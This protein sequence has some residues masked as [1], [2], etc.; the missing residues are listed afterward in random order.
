MNEPPTLETP[1]FRRRKSTPQGPDRRAG[2]LFRTDGA[3]IGGITLHETEAVAI[4]AVR[5]GYRVAEDQ[6]ERMHKLG[7]RLRS[8]GERLVGDEPHRQAVDHGEEILHKGVLAALAWVE[9]LAAEP[10]SPLHRFVVAQYKLLGGALGVDGGPAARPAS[11]GAARPGPPP[12]VPPRQHRPQVAIVH[13]AARRRVV[14]REF[15]LP[16]ECDTVPDELAFFHALDLQAP[17]IKA[18]LALKPAELTI[19]VAANS[20][21]GC[22]IAAIC[23]AGGRQHGWIEIEL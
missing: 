17:L 22:W 11:P 13:A 7:N 8:A 23:D 19:E 18:K 21:P 4:A 10:G 14:L 9:G 6:I 2:T 16:L 1:R 3:G 5:A 12:P 20:P 15:E